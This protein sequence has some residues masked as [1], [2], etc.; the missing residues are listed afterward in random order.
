[1]VDYFSSYLGL[2]QSVS[3]CETLAVGALKKANLE[4]CSLKSVDSTSGTVN[5]IG[6]HFS[7]NKEI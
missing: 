4:S 1:M 2:I 3:K 7:F 6:V 5:I